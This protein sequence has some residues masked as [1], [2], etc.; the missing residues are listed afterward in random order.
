[1]D[2]KLLY[3]EIELHNQCNRHCDFC[4]LGH[5]KSNDTHIIDIELYKNILYQLKN[6]NYNNYDKSILSFNGFYE[7]FTK[8]DVVVPLINYAKSILPKVTTI[9]NTNGDFLT[10]DIIKSLH[11][12]KL[13]IMDYDNREKLPYLKKLGLMPIDEG[14]LNERVKCLS[15]NT[16]LKMIVYRN[17]FIKH[18][19]LED[20]G[21]SLNKDN[22]KG[23]Y[24]WKNDLKP[25][26]IP[27][28]EPSYGVSID[29]YGNV[30]PCCHF[31]SLVPEHREFIFGNLNESSLKDIIN[32]KRFTDFKN[33]MSQPDS[34]LYPKQCQYCQKND[35]FRVKEYLKIK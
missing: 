3:V 19:E 13:N 6:M 7:P 1:M 21:G 28:Y 25:R 11:L 5:Y 17:N 22:V 35:E 16:A 14:N 9:I 24:K 12:D 31:R 20:R 30:Y 4:I 10:K 2:D 27:C 18:I 33:R 26:S 34:S 32:S 8:P 15:S 23:D 29:C